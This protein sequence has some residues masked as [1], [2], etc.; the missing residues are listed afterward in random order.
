MGHI[1]CIYKSAL[2][3]GRTCAIVS[4]LL[5]GKLPKNLCNSN[6]SAVSTRAVIVFMCTNICF[7]ENS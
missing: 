1:E 6:N 7:K 4:S 2:N 5:S 3:V